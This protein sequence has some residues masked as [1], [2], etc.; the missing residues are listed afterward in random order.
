M[1]HT[2]KIFNNQ[3][4]F[5]KLSFGWF[6]SSKNTA[7]FQ[8]LKLEIKEIGSEEKTFQIF[9]AD[10]NLLLAETKIKDLKNTDEG[11]EIILPEITIGGKNC[12]L[13]E[14]TKSSHQYA[15]LEENNGEVVHFDMT[16]LDNAKS[17][18]VT[19]NGYIMVCTSDSSN[20]E[21]MAL[22]FL[23]MY[24]LRKKVLKK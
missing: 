7:Q 10:K 17:L 14:V 22:L 16:N 5:G 4:F 12:M 2:C 9:D 1:L 18:P 8:T 19:F 15:W 23:G 24:I 6:L 3:D 11:S 21:H 13:K 20:T